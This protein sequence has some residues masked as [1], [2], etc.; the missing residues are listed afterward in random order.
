MPLRW[1]TRSKAARVV[2]LSPLQD[3]DI[4]VEDVDS[5][6]FYREILRRILPKK[7]RIKEI[8]EGGNRRGVEDLCA[9]HDFSRRAALF[10]I[11]GDFSWVRGD[12]P[13]PGVF[14]LDAYCIENLLI[15]PPA[16]VEHVFLL[17]GG[18]RSREEIAADLNLREW[19]VGLGQMLEDLFLLFAVANKLTPEL[20]T[21]GRGLGCVIKQVGRQTEICTAKIAG[22]CNEVRQHVVD[23][24]SQAAYDAAWADV[25]SR[26]RKRRRRHDVISGKDFLLPLLRI[27]ILGTVKD[28]SDKKSFYLRLATHCSRRRFA[29]LKRAVVGAVTATRVS[30]TQM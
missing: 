16:I 17:D 21:V 4:Y 2:L 22:L 5:R 30:T 28:C 18:R 9:K 29:R 24:T 12:P 3:I 7:I 11:D 13:P 6:E 25:F 26:H 1:P 8:F 19:I 20:P 15:E 23:R 14:Q 27:R 10:L